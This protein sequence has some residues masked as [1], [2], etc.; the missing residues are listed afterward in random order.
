MRAAQR[1]HREGICHGALLKENKETGRPE[2]SEN[3]RVRVIPGDPKEG[4]KRIARRVF[5]VNFE[6]AY[7]HPGRSCPST[8]EN[9]KMIKKG[10]CPELD[11]IYDFIAPWD[12]EYKKPKDIDKIIA[13]T[14]SPEMAT[15]R[16]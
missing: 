13:E 2:I 11:N 10:G 1:L 8:N 6:K 3:V 16:S 12:P 9:L 15:Y 4:K 5:F 7:R 14:A